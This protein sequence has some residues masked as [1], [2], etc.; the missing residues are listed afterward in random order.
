MAVI[1]I[2]LKVAWANWGTFYRWGIS[3]E[4]GDDPSGFDCSHFICEI[5]KSVGKIKPN[6]Y[7]RAQDLWNKF[8]DKKI[9]LGFDFF[10]MESLKEGVLVFYGKSETQITH[11]GMSVGDGFFISASG[12]D[13]STQTT[14]D[15]I[16]QNAFIK[17]RP[18][19]YRNDVVGFI[20]LF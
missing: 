1:D 4:G 19:D 20:D 12:G 14:E 16:E 8:K 3:K 5:L 7:Y 13:S 15:A 10:Q 17:V 6:Q 2:A 11:V 9:R 18:I